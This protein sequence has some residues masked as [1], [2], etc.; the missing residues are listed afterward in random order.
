M[1]CTILPDHVFIEWTKYFIFDDSTIEI[2]A[3]TP[4]VFPCSHGKIEV[5]KDDQIARLTTELTRLRSLTTPRPMSE[6][7][8]DETVVLCP[9]VKCGWIPAMCIQG[10]WY[11]FKDGKIKAI[12]PKCFLPM[13]PSVE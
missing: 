10:K 1:K 7:P 12:R 6:A 8:K 3:V 2:K 11:R 4:P 9:G 13:P 5:S